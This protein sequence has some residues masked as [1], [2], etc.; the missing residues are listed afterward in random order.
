MT[1]TWQTLDNALHKKNPISTPDAIMING[2]LSTNKTKM[3]ESFKNNFLT[4]CKQSEANEH[5]LP[6]HNIYLDNSPDT[7]LK[8]EQI[9]ITTVVQYINKLKPSHSCGHDGISSYIS[10]SI[11]KEVSPCST[12][13]INQ[14]IST[15]IFPKK[16]KIAKFIPVFKNKEKSQIKNYR[17]ISVLLACNV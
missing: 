9:D 17:P 4:L 12:L 3:A 6:S 7:I 1:K 15:G 8:F 2:I 13:N 5:H 11:A 10:K 16:L 14:S